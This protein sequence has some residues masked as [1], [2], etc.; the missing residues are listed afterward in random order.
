MTTPI[1]I[2]LK[3]SAPAG[4]GVA[5]RGWY[6]CR[7]RDHTGLVSRFTPSQNVA[8]RYGIYCNSGTRRYKGVRPSHRFRFAAAASVYLPAAWPGLRSTHRALCAACAFSLLPPSTES[9]RSPAH[10][11]RTRQGPAPRHAPRLPMPRLLR[12]ACLRHTPACAMP[13]CLRCA[14]TPRPRDSSNLPSCATFATLCD[15]APTPSVLHSRRPTRM[16]CHLSP[17]TRGEPS[18]SFPAPCSAES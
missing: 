17:P 2:G 10:P 6:G 8:G 14:A 3:C 9:M 4:Q 16:A 18:Q 11:T 13:A 1:A 12:H 15:S 7:D 5:T